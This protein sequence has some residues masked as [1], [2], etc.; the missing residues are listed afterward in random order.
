[1]YIAK[2]VFTDVKCKFVNRKLQKLNKY[3]L[4]L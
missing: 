2:D 1:M 4:H 3:S